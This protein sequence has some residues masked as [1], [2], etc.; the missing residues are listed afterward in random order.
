MRSFMGILL[1]AALAGAAEPR[2]REIPLRT[3]RDKIA[4]GWAGQMIGVSFGAPTEFRF[5]GRIAEGE[6]PP[7]TPDRVRNALNQDD[8]YVDMTF[9]KVLDE[10]GLDASTE[11]FA[12]EFRQVRYPLWHANLAARRNLRRGIAPRWAGH[13]LY[14]A[15]A[16]DIDFQIEADFIGLMA[17]GLFQSAN[18]IAWR[19]G[20]VMNYG[21]GIYGGMFVAGMYAAA[22]FEND[23]QRIVE[24]GL[25]VLPRQ[26]PYA[27]LISDV[28]LWRRQHPQDWREV[29]RRIQQKWDRDDPC[30][31]GALRPFNIDAKLN[32]AY[33]A[34]ALLY[35]GGDFGRTLE[36]ATRSGQDSDCNPASAGGILGVVL[37]YEGIPEAW[38]S[39]I[40]AIADQ[41][42]RYTDYSFRTIVESTFR[43]ALALIERT[44][45]RREDDK[46]VVRLQPPQPA[47]LEGWRYG[48]VAERI[49]VD[50]ARWSWKG[51]WRQEKVWRVSGEQGAE[52]AVRFEG[53]GAILVGPYL[54]QGGKADVYLDGKL[55]RS[56]D[57]FSD[58]SSVKSQ[59][60]VWHVFGLKP[61]LHQVRL[62]VRGE[63]YGGSG[64]AEVALQDVVVFR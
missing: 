43:R 8:L 42:F 57:V 2:Y 24:A 11:D 34:L 64:G 58:E 32:G 26:C 35:G 7:W 6:L 52:A 36:I 38:K 12:A 30:P 9:A 55:H 48:A 47:K 45:G 19:A 53:T 37:G 56:V 60:A 29:W 17:P 27:R 3:L 61:G 49:P 20:R 54:P 59:E 4:G 39:G 16:N 33:I 22:F 5:L 25:A 41:K 10:R 63:P 18:Q 14:N 46:A 28:L 44:G 40:P 51:S 31:A 13:P 1:T 23:P 21:D 62:V 50:D 15:H